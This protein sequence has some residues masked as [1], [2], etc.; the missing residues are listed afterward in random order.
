MSRIPPLAVA[1]V[2]AAGA[3]AFPAVSEARP[4]DVD[5]HA[6]KTTLLMSGS[7]SVYPL[8]RSLATAFVKKHPGVAKF[9]IA[10]GGSDTGITDVA[11]GRVA[12]GASSREHQD[13]DPAGLYMYKI[14]RD[15][16]CVV[17]NTD[18]PI[19]NLS[20]EQVQDIFSGK[21]RR[22]DDVQGAKVTGPIALITRTQASGTQDAFRNIF[23]GLNLNVAGSA[24]QKATNGLVQSSVRSNKNAI[25]Y[26]DFRFTAGTYAVPYKGVGCT[27]RNAK[28]AQYPGIRNFWYV[29][30]GA[31]KGVAKKFIDFARSSSVQSSIVAKNYVTYK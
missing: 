17:T 20:Q 29:T 8:S 30:R 7:T 27:L 6:S 4:A 12:I 14:A 3:V 21:V 19:A 23:M 24:E 18:N 2:A 10:Q 15:G 25:G 31:A 13:G 28:S 22:W 11:H 16:V 5:A 9:T 1:A 26:V